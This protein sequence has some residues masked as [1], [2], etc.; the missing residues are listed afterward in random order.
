METGMMV[1][2]T[3]GCRISPYSS[4]SEGQEHYDGDGA[5]MVA[6]TD[7]PIFLIVGGAGALRWRRG[8]R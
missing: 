6:T 5:V 7:K 1:A 2:T 8:N 3:N 4:S